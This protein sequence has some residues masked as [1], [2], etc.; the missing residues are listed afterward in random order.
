MMAQLIFA[1]WIGGA[2]LEAAVGG[3]MWRRKLVREYP[4][5]FSYIASQ[6]LKC[7]VMVPIYLKHDKELYMQAFAFFEAIDAGLSLAVIYEL[8]RITFRDYEGIRE[9]GWMLLRWAVV[10]LMAVAV[11]AA[12]SAPGSGSDTKPFLAGLFAL[13]QSISVLRAGL[14]FL[15][16]VFHSSLGL[17]WAPMSLGI[18]IGFATVT[19]VGLI[20]YSLRS[21]F[22]PGVTPALSLIQTAAYDCALLE[23]LYVALRPNRERV[24]TLRRTKWDVE[25]WNQALLELLQR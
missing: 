18:A 1:I 11:I 20:T 9:L 24:V 25:G 22:G 13:E 15:L 12:A 2:V 7:L 19:A 23:W 21:H 8:F 3:A 5:F 4:L 6:L 16:F 17:R 14:L 10:V